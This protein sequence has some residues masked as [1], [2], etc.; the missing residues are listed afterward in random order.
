MSS[1]STSRDSAQW[2]RWQMPHMLA[3]APAANDREAEQ[4]AAVISAEQLEALRQQAR[5][6]GWAQGLEEGR[7]AARAEQRQLAQRWLALV[8][9]LAQPLQSLDASVE[10]EL[11][12]LAI[13]LG[14]QLARRELS[15]HPE[16]IVTIVREGLKALPAGSHRIQI[17]LNPED[18]RLVTSQLEPDGEHPWR[19]VESQGISRGGCQITSDG[20]RLDE[21][22]ETRLERLLQPLLGTDAKDRGA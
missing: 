11:T 3:A 6:E 1:F 20:A 2:S 21:R 18:A 10:E 4:V 22:L 16:Q 17:H 12:R 13:A 7:Q 15:L 9:Q 14:S 19:L 5:E 8:D